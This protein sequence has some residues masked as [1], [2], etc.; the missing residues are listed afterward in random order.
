MAR[1]LESQVLMIFIEDARDPVGEYDV[2]DL[3]DVLL[4]VIP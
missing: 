4:L 2:T 3:R 1:S